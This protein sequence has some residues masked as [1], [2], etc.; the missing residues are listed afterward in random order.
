MMFSV[1]THKLCHNW[2]CE[3]SSNWREVIKHGP[4]VASCLLCCVV[5]L[6]PLPVT[7]AATPLPPPQ[8][9]SDRGRLPPPE[10]RSAHAPAHPSARPQHSHHPRVRGG[11]EQHPHDDAARCQVVA[12]HLPGD[13][14]LRPRRRS[15]HAC[16][17]SLQRGQLGRRSLEG[18]V[19]GASERATQTWK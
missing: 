8:V 7:H 14:L 11:R 1:K 9:H 10:E 19:S 17:I 2:Y 16:V 18:N 5:L 15:R 4:D 12:L 3:Q 13:S 6:S